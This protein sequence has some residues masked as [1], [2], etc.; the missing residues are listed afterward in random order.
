[1]NALR[2]NDR[3][4]E[5]AVLQQ[6]LIR[7][8]YPVEV[9]HIYDETTERAVMA[10]QAALGLAA[11]GIAG[12]N[13]Y[14]ALA[15]GQ[16]DRKHLTQADIIAAAKKLGVTPA[17]VHA[18]TEVESHGAGFLA[19]G[20]PVI[21]FERHVMYRRLA[22]AVGSTEAASAARQFPNVVNAKVGGYEGGAAEYLRLDVAAHIDA[23]IA[24]ESASW[25]AFQV[26]GYHWE[27]LGYASVAE[28]CARMEK[29]EGEHLDAFVRFVAS[30]V[31]L[32][33][34]LRTRNWTA[35]A[36]GYN[37]VGYARNH[38]PERLAQAYERYAGAMESV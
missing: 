2:F 1:M 21:R 7:Q 33:R 3:G 15:H 10:L 24:Y 14:A 16:R 18:V 11:D 30:D 12:P 19:D 5:V 8:G 31:T 13:T 29:S 22:A 17:C 6:R 35:F 20:R 26:M 27:R 38:Y 34:A 25:G 23:A 36:K 37:G 9:T 32:L 28:F 4:T